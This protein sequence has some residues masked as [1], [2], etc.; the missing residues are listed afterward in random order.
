[1]KFAIKK[2]NAGE[3]LDKFL[4]GRLDKLSR[5]QIQKL[6]KAGAVLADGRA[7]LPHYFLKEGEKIE[8]LARKANAVES[9]PAKKI[10]PE[11]E[12]I[13]DTDEFLII[14]KP[15]GL[16]VHGGGGVKEKT[17]V[18][19]LL[20][21]Y[22]RLKKIGEDP[23]RPAIIHRLDKDVSGLMVIPK[24]ED[25]F[26]NLKKQFQGRR[27][28]KEYAGLVYGQI[29]REE[30]EINFPI[31]RSSRGYKMA[32]LPLTGESSQTGRRAITRIK[33]AKK[34]INYT[35]LEIKI[36][37]GRTHQIRVHLAAYGHPLVGDDLYGTA[38]TK[39]KNK[40]IN[41]NRV[42]LVARRLAFTDLAGQ[43]H[44]YEINLPADLEKF[45]ATIK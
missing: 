16:I 40:K 23:E 17:L 3:R 27:T 2:E 7:V 36:V 37:T 5:S 29:K 4:A 44:A 8:V 12:I 41:L 11:I 26:A 38:R 35:F 22:P 13:D 21:K 15:A 18:D 33:T 14:N 42:F 19:I 9:E 10:L 25:A 24:T 32:A 31:S 45:L 28:E 1:M 39:I 34:F 6:V 20:K 30:A 43:Q